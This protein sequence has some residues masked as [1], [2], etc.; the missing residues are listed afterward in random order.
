[1]S[2]LMFPFVEKKGM[3][4]A[5]ADVEASAGTCSSGHSQPQQ[6]YDRYNQMNAAKYEM[7]HVLTILKACLTNANGCS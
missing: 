4:Q 2:A 7:I 6:D 1:M 3:M 5:T